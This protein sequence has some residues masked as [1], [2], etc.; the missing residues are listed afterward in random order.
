MEI[1]KKKTDRDE[2]MQDGV[3][4]GFEVWHRWRMEED[5]DGL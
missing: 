1:R 3:G 5:Q 2:C 4:V